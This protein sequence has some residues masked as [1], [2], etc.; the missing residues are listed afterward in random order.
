MAVKDNH[1]VFTLVI[2]Q[3]PI[4]FFGFMI[5]EV[6]NFLNKYQIDW[7]RTMNL[8]EFNIER[9]MHMVWMALLI[10]NLIIVL[11]VCVL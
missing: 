6:V 4:I 1:G 2:M 10:F 7:R 3:L 11:I 9:S 5:M 8:G